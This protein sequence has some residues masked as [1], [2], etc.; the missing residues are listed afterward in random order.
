M[1]E[2]PDMKIAFYAPLKPAR[3]PTPSG[4]RLMARL[5]VKAL[6]RSGENHVEVASEL[7]AYLREPD[8][9]A[10]CMLEEQAERER[11]RIERLWR[12]DGRPDLWFT[13]HPYYKS[14]D[15]IGPDLC[16]AFDMPYVT[17]EA[18]Y[19]ER[20]N[21]GVWTQSQRRVLDAIDQAAVNICF[22]SR[23]RAGLLAKSPY[24]SVEMVRPFVDISELHLLDPAPLPHQLITVGMM[25]DGNKLESYQMLAAALARLSDLPW[26]LSI[27]GDGP[28]RGDV[29]AAFSDLAP[30]R[31]TF[32][33]LIER[34]AIGTMLSQGSVFLWP[35]CREAYGLS[36]LE[37]QAA[38]LPVIAQADGGVPEVVIHDRTGL[39]TPAGDLD[40]Y[41]EAIRTLL[42]QDAL[43]QSM[44]REAMILAR[45]E[46]SLDTAAARIASILQ[47]HVHGI[48]AYER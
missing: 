23:D 6:E 37:A 4:D 17:A 9:Q 20:R 27:V 7:R 30:G 28:R 18:S 44:S 33:G 8:A 41:A 19:S 43:R 31:I 10:Y 32:H 34:D 40:A 22:T 35:G 2:M 12:K 25:R 24:L 29:E 16:R 14:P 42:T 3:H 11:E 21:I 26:R 13:Y 15:L 46:R 1:L 5:L 38:G 45:R 47:Q 36:Y 39:L 48:K